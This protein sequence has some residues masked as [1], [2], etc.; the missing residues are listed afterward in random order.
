MSD[1]ITE[2]FI[3]EYS[4][5][6]ALTAQ[7]MMAMTR[8]AVIERPM[9]SKKQ[10]VDQVGQIELMKKTTRNADIPILDVPHPRRWISAT[11]YWGAEFINE[12]DVLQTLNDPSNASTQAFASS[13]L[14][15]CPERSR[16]VDISGAS[17]PRNRTFQG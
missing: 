16:G 14:V 15:A 10:A 5:G 6:I 2:H 13:P 17:M 1:F 12:S 7:Q 4:A 8:S 11:P 3:N 9:H